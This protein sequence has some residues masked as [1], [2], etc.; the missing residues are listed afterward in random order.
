VTNSTTAT[1]SIVCETAR[2][3]TFTVGFPEKTEAVL[4]E[5]SENEVKGNEDTECG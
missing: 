3:G 2:G 4:W 1:G 5:T